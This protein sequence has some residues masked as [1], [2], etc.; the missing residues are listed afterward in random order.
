MRYNIIR[1]MDI[2]NGE[3][4]GISLFCQ[5]CSF[6]CKN[7]F[8]KETWD[9]K[10]GK[11]WTDEIKEKFIKLAE[12]DHI[13]RISI[14][15]GEPLHDNNVEDIFSLCKELKGKYPNKKIWL[16]S[17]H[18]IEELL[19]SENKL[20]YEVLQYIDVLIDGRYIHE[21]RDV[22]CKWKGST[23]QRVIK[24]ADYIK[25]NELTFS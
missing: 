7:C 19:A 24:I 25:E 14:L 18:T 2:S 13:S 4:V 3:G 15:G 10:G 16:Y 8:N 22:N 23:N 12:F 5:G 9:F 17:G 1:K 21:L 6:H 11:E 20:K